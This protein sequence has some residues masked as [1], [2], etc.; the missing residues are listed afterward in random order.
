MVHV[1]SLF[2]LC[3][4][5]AKDAC[6]ALFM[7]CVRTRLKWDKADVTA[8]N[9]G[10]LPPYAFHLSCLIISSKVGYYVHIHLLYALHSFMRGYP[11]YFSSSSH[12]GCV[13]TQTRWILTGLNTYLVGVKTY[14]HMLREHVDQE[15]VC[16][17]L[18]CN[19]ELTYKDNGE[20]STYGDRCT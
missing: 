14:L 10:H 15:I 4:F 18:G 7:H 17:C 8:N 16:C 9:A 1:L 20:W 12:K 19:K 2:S 5:N 3:C 13:Y 6:C 11:L